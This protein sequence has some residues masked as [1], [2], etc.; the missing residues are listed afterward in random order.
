MTPANFW[1]YQ[2]ATPTPRDAPAGSPMTR[3]QWESLSPGMRREITRQEV[4]DKLVQIEQLAADTAADDHPSFVRLA[5]AD[6]D[7]KVR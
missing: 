7:R 2:A 1:S 4:A 3:G 5:A 6:L